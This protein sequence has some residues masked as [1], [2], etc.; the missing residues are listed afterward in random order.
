MPWAAR[1][2]CPRETATVALAVPAR[3]EPPTCGDAEQF[4]DAAHCNEAATAD[5]DGYKLALIN[6]SVDGG[7]VNTAH[8]FASLRDADNQWLHGL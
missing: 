3:S 2:N 1:R 4:L 5:A 8:Q 7:A 6:Q